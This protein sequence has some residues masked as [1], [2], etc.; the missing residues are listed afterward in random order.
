MKITRDEEIAI[1][2]L[3]G[4]GSIQDV[5]EYKNIVQLKKLDGTNLVLTCGQVVEQLKKEVPQ[6]STTIFNEWLANVMHLGTYEKVGKKRVFQPNDR[7]SKGII[8]QGLAV[9]GTSSTNKVKAHYTQSMVNRILSNNLESLRD[10]TQARVTG[11]F[12]NK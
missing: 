9:T 10:Y 1:K 12:I 5:I 7:Y 3:R 11:T 2:L 6:L 4:E 8:K